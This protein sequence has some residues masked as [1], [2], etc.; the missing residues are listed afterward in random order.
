MMLTMTPT[1]WTVLGLVWLAAVLPALAVWA[2]RRLKA[3]RERRDAAW[4]EIHAAHVW[5]NDWRK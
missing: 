2:G 3:Q 5:P 4:R 1:I